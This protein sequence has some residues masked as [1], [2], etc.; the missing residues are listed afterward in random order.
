VAQP[1]KPAGLSIKGCQ[2]ATDLQ[3]APVLL[4]AAMGPVQMSATTLKPIIV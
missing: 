4:T 3:S 2:A 1:P